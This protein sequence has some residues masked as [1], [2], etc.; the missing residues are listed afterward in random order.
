MYYKP[1]IYSTICNLQ[2]VTLKVKGQINLKWVKSK[3][4]DKRYIM[5]TLIRSKRRKWQLLQCSCLEN[6]RERGAWWAAVCGVAQR[7][8]RL[9]RLSSSSSS[10]VALITVVLV[11]KNLL[12]SAG[13]VRDVSLIPGS[14]RSPGEG[15]ATHS[16]IHAWRTPGTEE[17]GGLQSTGL[18]RVG[19][20]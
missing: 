1:Q 19:H 20:G 15:K 10:R 16:S 3:S 5:L 17:P 6:P 4:F 13:D 12:S 14:G 11:V 8:T 9:K 18:R 7:R 2:E